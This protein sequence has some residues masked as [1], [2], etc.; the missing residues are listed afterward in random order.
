MREQPPHPRVF[1]EKSPQSIE[2]KGRE[3]GKERQESSRVRKRLEGKEIEEVE[4]RKEVGKEVL[5][6]RG[7]GETKLRRVF[8]SDDR[9]DCRSCQSIKWVLVFRDWAQKA[10]HAQGHGNKRKSK[11]A[12]FSAQTATCRLAG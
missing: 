8:T 9:T 5:L 11:P 4:E 10:E 1:W 12:P 7:A 6:G 2:N 3:V